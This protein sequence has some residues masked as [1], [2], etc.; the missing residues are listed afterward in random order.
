MNIKRASFIT[1]LT[2][3]ASAVTVTVGASPAAADSYTSFANVYT[4]KCLEVENSSRSNGARVQQWD[5]N[6][7]GGMRWYTRDAGG[8]Y[9][10]IVNANSGKC[11]E[12]D[13]SSRNNGARAQQ[14]DCNGQAGAKWSI[15]KYLEWFGGSEIKNSSGKILEIENSS[16]SNGAR[17]QQWEYKGQ[18]G[19]IWEIRLTLN[20]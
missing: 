15:S 6:G 4:G 5:C 9:S 14:W 20:S 10:Y 1:S 2:I 19:V 18:A 7:Q 17:A 13:G 16:R 8:G 11:L 3:V 12:I